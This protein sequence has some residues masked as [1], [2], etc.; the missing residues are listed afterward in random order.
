LYELTFDPSWIERASAIAREM[1]KWFGDDETGAFYDTASDAERLITRPRDATD[2]AMPSGM[3]LA[4]ELLLHLGDLT[5]NQ[6]MSERGRR[7]I[8]SMTTAL[9]KYPTAFG[10][11]LG[12]ADM[13]FTARLKLQ[14]PEPDR[15]R[16]SRYWSGRLQPSTFHRWFLPVA[17][18]VTR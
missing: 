15:M 17:S 8:N 5:G 3:S 14:S 2:N 9:E 12:A 6:S 7:V 4:V 13:W 16:D 11:M 10:H 1:I 18:R